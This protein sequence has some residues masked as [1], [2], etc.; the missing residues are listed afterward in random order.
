M[1]IVVSG[2]FIILRCLGRMS[3]NDLSY[4]FIVI[5]AIVSTTHVYN[6]KM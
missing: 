4:E 1:Y 6:V 3:V 5:S 2:I